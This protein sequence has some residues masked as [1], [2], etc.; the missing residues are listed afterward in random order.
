MIMKSLTSKDEVE[1]VLDATTKLA[2]EKILNGELQYCSGVENEFALFLVLKEACETSGFQN[3]SIELISGHKFPDVVFKDANI[4]LEI[5]GHKSGDRILGN[6]IMGSTPS[7]SSPAAIYLLV[8]NDSARDVVWRDYFDCVVGAE[9]THSPRFV[10]KPDC[11]ESES[12]F[13]NQVGQIG[14]ASEVCLGPGGFKSEVILAK[15][16]AK[17]LAEGNIPWWITPADDGVPKV[18]NPVT[19]QMAVIKYS[20][21]N[22]KFERPILLKT[23]IIGF[24]EILGKSQ[25]KFDSALVWGLMRKSV[26]ITRD[27]FT[28]GGRVAVSIP[29]ICSCEDLLLPQVLVTA[30]NLLSGPHKVSSLDISEIWGIVADPSSSFTARLKTLMMQSGISAHAGS[31]LHHNC[32]CS[33][34]SDDDFSKKI[35]DWLLDSFDPRTIV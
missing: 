20:K 10:L 3:D 34:L 1:H 8:W 24:P 22:P 25:A 19:S 16:R 21:L 17:A 32:E 12:L 28:A 6:S 18:N 26:L 15:M 4:G 13:G 14:N 7:L 30:R 11:S 23:M 29:Q 33:T 27:A 35:T 9:V 31:T 5:K 2:R